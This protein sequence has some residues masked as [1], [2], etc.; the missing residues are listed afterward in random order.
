MPI[1]E[2]TPEHFDDLQEMVE[3][4]PANM[5]LS[6]RPFVDY[7]YATRPWC[8]LYLYVSD[9][10]KVVGT[11]GRELLRNRASAHSL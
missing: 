3:R 9:S 4:V 5:N 1:I 11:L 2:Y 8:K 7:Y 10:G 6:H